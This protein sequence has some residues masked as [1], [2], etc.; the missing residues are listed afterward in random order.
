MA[1]SEAGWD[2]GG[3]EWQA[4]PSS[5]NT[6]GSAGPSVFHRD[7]CGNQY[8]TLLA[9]QLPGVGMDGGL[10]EALPNGASS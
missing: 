3:S 5:R 7:G 6:H 1:Q 10:G 4:C 9:W 8:P 2:E